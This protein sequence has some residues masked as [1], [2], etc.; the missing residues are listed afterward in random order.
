MAGCDIPQIWWN[1]RYLRS[2]AKT[3][4]YKI[5]AESGT[6]YVSPIKTLDQFVR[7]YRSWR[8]LDDAPL[9]STI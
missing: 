7:D 2:M 1:V 4:Y 6:R 3:P 5:I 9:Y 8:Y